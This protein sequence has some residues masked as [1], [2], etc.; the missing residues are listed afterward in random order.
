MK[1]RPDMDSLERYTLRHKWHP[2]RPHRGYSC[3][4]DV[5]AMGDESLYRPSELGEAFVEPA[6]VV[7]GARSGLALTYVAGPAGLPEGASV[8]FA[9]RG[10]NPL[11]KD[12]DAE[13]RVEGPAHC[14]LEVVDRYSF[15]LAS[16]CL[17]EGDRVTLRQA[18]Y[19]WTVL[20]GR[21]EL[22]VV[23]NCHT[24][25]PEQRLPA[26]L[27]VDVLPR[28]L[29]RLEATLPCTRRPGE[30]LHVHVTARD[31]YDNRVLR[32]DAV[33]VS[34]GTMRQEV[35]LCDGLSRTRFEPVLDE[36]VRVQAVSEEAALATISNPCVVSTD[37]QLYLGDL[38]CHDHLS[39]AEG[40]PDEVYRWAREDRNLDFVSVSP[41]SHGWHDNETWTIAKYMNE[42]YLEEGYFVTFLGFEWQHSSF[43][44]KVIHFLGGDQPYLPVDDPRYNTPGKLYQALRQSDALVISH[45]VC[46]PLPR[47]V[48]GTDWDT[49]D[50]GLERLVELWSMHGSGEGYSLEDRPLREVDPSRTV[51]QALRKGLRLGFVAGSDTH[52]GRP[53][54]SAKEPSGY[55]GG[56]A[57]A[58]APALTRRDLFSA[59]RAR[60]TYALTGARIVLRMTVNGA[61]MG[62]EIPQ[63]D[64]A[65]IRIDVWAPQR[66][67]QVELIKNTRLLRSFGPFE[68]ECHITFEDQVQGPSFYHCRVIQA[69]GHLAVSSPVWVG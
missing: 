36:T 5:D 26:P 55:W 42:R 1:E 33:T 37:L 44:D 65:D 20:A 66:I 46:Y 16:G 35:H 45:H 23:I 14:Q 8:T 50:T 31:E 13:T 59:L 57:A 3:N 22:K 48:P 27:V 60:R 2:N 62:S 12:S 29:D 54:G 19:D 51:M 10:Q 11:G 40:Y 64:Q 69:D 18:P 53:G 32:Q 41:Q 43:G 6:K 56:L 38:H 47:W 25:Q 39:E 63:A 15:S 34:C 28:P 17:R 24:G 67:A 58:W 4:G 7:A 68:D 9:I 49:V 21:R 30:D 52:S 61:W